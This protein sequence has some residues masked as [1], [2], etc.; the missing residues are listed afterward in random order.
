MG[1][2]SLEMIL[3]LI[4]NHQGTIAAR[5]TQHRFKI[6]IPNHCNLTPYNIKWLY[7]KYHISTQFFMNISSNKFSKNRNRISVSEDIEARWW[8]YKL[9]V[10]VNLLKEIIAKVGNSAQKVKEELNGSK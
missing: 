2:I 4:S 5:T 3:H 7:S 9:G 6:T 10:T 1:K 8:S